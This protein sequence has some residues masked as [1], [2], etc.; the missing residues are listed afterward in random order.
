[1]GTLTPFSHAPSFS[2]PVSAQMLPL[3][4]PVHLSWP[5]FA[6]YH[7]TLFSSFTAVFSIYMDLLT[8][9]CHLFTVFSPHCKL[10]KAKTRPV[11]AA[12][13]SPAPGTQQVQSLYAEYVNLHTI[14]GTSLVP[15]PTPDLSF[16]FQFDHGLVVL[17]AWPP[18]SS[19]SITWNILEMQVL[20]QSGAAERSLLPHRAGKRGASLVSGW[21][22]VPDIQ[23]S[24]YCSFSQARSTHAFQEEKPGCGQ[25]IKNQFDIWLLNRNKADLMERR[26]HVSEGKPFPASLVC[27]SKLSKEWGQKED[28]SDMQSLRN[29]LPCTL[30]GKQKKG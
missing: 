13:A 28:I 20:S 7:S 22:Q 21:R 8:H 17:K 27:P 12:D 16:S 25:R 5:P 18:S 4:L 24:L 14:Y 6:Q 3:P 30:L 15:P 11:S 10:L 2:R 19:S 26:W 1:M 23:A 9:F 29:Y